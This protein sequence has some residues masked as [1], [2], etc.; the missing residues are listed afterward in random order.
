MPPQLAGSAFE[1]DAAGF[2]RQRRHGVGLRSRRIKRARARQ[3]GNADFPF[4][5]CVIALK[6]CIRDGPIGQ[7]SAG[8]RPDFAALDEVNF[9]EA[10][11]IGGEMDAGPADHPAVDEPAL[12][13]RLFLGGFAKGR[14][15]KVRMIRELVS[16]QD[17]HFVV[18]EV[19]FGQVRPLLQDDHAK[20]IRGK[21]FGEDAA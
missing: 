5:F 10:P 19:R 14:G 1:D 4:D 7:S 12:P 2:H 8:N 15:L 13:L 16:L 17:F 21:L 6:V 9:V 11:V 3:T 20:A 18:G